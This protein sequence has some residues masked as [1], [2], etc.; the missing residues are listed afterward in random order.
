MPAPSPVVTCSGLSFAWPDGTDVFTGLSLIISPGRT[1]LA[2]VNG[3]GKSTLLRLI[4]GELAPSAG[5]VSVAGELGYL[6][7]NLA[8]GAPETRVEEA[9]GIAG[10]RAA[11]AAIEAGGAAVLSWR[12]ARG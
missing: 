9:L 1:G 7:Q 4:A 12:V 5:S 11:V 8:L 3:S 10:I 2:G 6:P